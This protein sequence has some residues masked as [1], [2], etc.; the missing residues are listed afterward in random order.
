MNLEKSQLDLLSRLFESSINT[1]S[2]I[3]D[4][5]GQDKTTVTLITVGVTLAV[6][7]LLRAMNV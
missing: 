7:G 2:E 4:I 5:S 1:S 6:A 3:A